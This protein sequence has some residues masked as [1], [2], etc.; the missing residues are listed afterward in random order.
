MLVSYKYIGSSWPAPYAQVWDSRKNRD[1]YTGM[2]RDELEA[3]SRKHQQAEFARFACDHIFEVQ[4]ANMCFNLALYDDGPSTAPQPWHSTVDPTWTH[5]VVGLYQPFSVM[6]NNEANLCMTVNKINLNKKDHVRR[7]KKLYSNGI[8]HCGD[9]LQKEVTYY[10]HQR[11]S[12]L[13]RS[14]GLVL[15]QVAKN[16]LFELNKVGMSLVKACE[17]PIRDGPAG[18]DD[19]YSKLAWQIHS[20]LHHMGLDDV[21]FG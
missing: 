14:M 9:S 1:P 6:L 5:Q 20:M 8:S 18:I 12:E 2:T 15:P 11:N 19:L 3:L 10:L 7:Y 13:Y 4:L 21:S 16:I 17:Q